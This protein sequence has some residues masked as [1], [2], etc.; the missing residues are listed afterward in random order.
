MSLDLFVF[1]TTET[2]TRNYGVFAAYILEPGGHW[3][4]NMKRNAAGVCI[5]PESRL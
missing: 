2:Q 5:G 1:A 3:T 4:M